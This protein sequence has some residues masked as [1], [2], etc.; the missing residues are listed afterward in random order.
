MTTAD[1]PALPGADFDHR[2]SEWSNS[3]WD[4]W[5]SLRAEDSLAHSENYGG[6]Y[7]A[8]RY[9]D[10]C[11]MARDPASFSSYPQVTIPDLPVPPFPPINYDP[12][13]NRIYRQ[14]VNPFFSPAK[15]ESYE[16]W[17]RELAKARID[18]VMASDR[19]DVPA[20]IGIPLTREIILRIMGI[21]N[22]PDEVNRWSDDL[23]QQSENA[24]KAGEAL[25]GFLAGELQK[26]R[27]S[28]GTDFISGLVDA[29]YE[30]RELNDGEILQTTLLV[31]L[32]GLE[33]TNSAIAGSIWYLVEHP[34]LQK[35]L[36]SADKN[37]WR[38]AMDEFV[39][40]TSPAAAN[41]RH[42]RRD[43]TVHGCPM[44]E[45]D[46]ALLIWGSANRDEREFPD[47]DSIVLD[48][49]PNRHVGFGM[50]PHRC[51]GS[52][53]AKLVMQIVFERVVP[54]LHKWRL[55]GPDAIDWAGAE[56][57]GIDKLVLVRL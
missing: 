25:V 20:D 17:I 43:V 57:R 11:A 4:T 37:T 28:P 42:V 50:G 33:T 49:H 34:E 48:R 30:D 9:G 45:G 51:L 24:A 2:T 8:S 16:P 27:E 54:E 55:D 26:R 41:A 40:W 23:I 39:R 52:H 46:R 44:G 10:V 13:A 35:E 31:L 12:P 56:T 36:L 22:V 7:V 3:P 5:A 1:R 21:E 47:P 38:L 53:L 15:V 32:A 14:I 6:Y 18:P 19:I 29:P